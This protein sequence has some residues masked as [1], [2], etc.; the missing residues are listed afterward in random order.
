[1]GSLE[2][3]LL[4]RSLRTLTLRVHQQSATANALANWLYDTWKQSIEVYHTSIAHCQGHLV[5]KSQGTGWSG[6]MSVVFVSADQAKQFCASLSLFTHATSLGGCESLVEWR[7]KSDP[8][9]APG[10][11]RLSIGLEN[12]EDLRDDISNALNQI[13]KS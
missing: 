10:L 4:T 9:I 5:A 3:W 12:Y 8:T 1:M 11:C 2:A 13:F 6:V 7:F